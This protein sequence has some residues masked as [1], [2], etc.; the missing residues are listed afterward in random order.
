MK[1]LK[2]KSFIIALFVL[3]NTCF[4]V[5]GA[6]QSDLNKKANEKNSIQNDI[7]K[8]KNKQ[9]QAKKEKEAIDNNIKKI[10]GQLDEISDS[11]NE[12]G[13]RKAIILKELA[14]AQA[15]EDKQTQTLKKRL[16][17][18]YED[19][20]TSYFSILMSSESIFDFFYNLEI[21]RQLSE[22]DDKILNELKE[23]KEKITV[24]KQE[25]DTIIAKEKGKEQELKT[26]NAN[27]KS[28]SDKKQSYVKELDKNIEELKKELDRVE[29]EEAALRAEIAKKA[30]SQSGSNVP[31]NFVGGTFLWPAPGVTKIT[32]P[33]GYRVHPTTG[34]YKLHTGIDIACFSGHNVLAAADGV[35]IISG[36]H[37]A[38]GK[39][40]SINHGGGI[41]TLYAH[42]SS[43]LVSSGQSVKKG[44]VIAK[45]G[46]TGWSTG[47]HLHFEVLINGSPVNPMN[48]FN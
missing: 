21:L 17:V 33:F 15:D 4:T 26:A 42:N 34:Q 28:Q 47:P 27:L 25:L 2:T 8:E 12:L 1:N 9:N 38:Y 16:R 41:S 5:W 43:L 7:N 13:S 22:H 31:K 19:G 10:T 14:E 18:I 30:G 32:S 11:L 40:I 45:S 29:R 20:A 46:N 36:N 48:Y 6:S 44:Q 35:V 37:T 3:F 39:Y 23:T 24:K